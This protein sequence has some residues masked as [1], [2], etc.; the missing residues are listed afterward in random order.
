VRTR[1]GMALITGGPVM[2]RTLSAFTLIE[3]LVVI[4][5]CA[6]LIGLLIPAV[7]KVR[8][9]A[10]RIK[11]QNNLRQIGLAVHS[12]ENANGCLPPNGSWLSP[13]GESHSV[14]ARILPHIEHA[15]L[16]QMVD[17]KAPAI[18]QPSVVGQRITIYVCPS[19]PNDGPHPGTPPTYPAGYGFGLGDWF[20]END[21]TGQFGNGVFPGAR[22]PSQQGIRL[23]DVA[24]GT[25]TTVG[26]AD[27]KTLISYLVSG[28][29]PATPPA[30]PSELL[31][32]R[33][34]LNPAGGHANWV[35]GYVFNTGLTF[36]FPPN[37]AMLYTNPADGVTYDVDWGGDN[38][39]LVVGAWISRSYHPGGV[40][41]LFIDGSVKF[42]AN[43]IDQAT[44]RALGTRNGGEVVDSTKY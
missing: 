30:T 37:T 42:V 33:A 32:L 41:A 15:S 26:V 28:S 36:V 19:D 40:N 27:V 20:T 9:A 6:A 25:S 39:T 17:L 22:Y 12:F 35:G 13:F 43:S 16:Y 10:L 8:E 18:S 4:A 29:A 1:C 14:F 7:L 34:T 3:L 11:C 21:R 5:I 2:R 23:A 38:Y 44:W 31:A 24:D